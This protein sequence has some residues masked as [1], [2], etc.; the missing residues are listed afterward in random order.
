MT[1]A[2][3]TPPAAEPVTLAEAK[4]HLRVDVADDDAAIAALVAAA[5][6]HVESLTGLKL[7][8]QVWRLYRDGWPADGLVP[9]PLFPVSAIGPV[10]VYDAAGTPATLAPAAYRLDT[11]SR[12]PRL[13]LEA[14]AAGPGIGLN[15]IEIDVTAGF[16]ASAAAVPAGLRQA[17][18][19]LTAR[20]YED[21]DGAALGV[22]APEAADRLSDLL[23]PF[24]S[25]RLA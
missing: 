15:G 3:I 20:W 2:L 11:R 14:G 12:P 25:P 18:L 6:R 24:R 17:V 4:A 1:V 21:R 16:G 10:V 19:M 13:R 7:I 22:V 23:A 5:R 9:I 8:D